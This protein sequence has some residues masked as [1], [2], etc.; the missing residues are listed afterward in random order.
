MRMSSVPLHFVRQ[1]QG[2]LLVLSHALGCDLSM[3]DG[4][5]ERLQDRYTVLRYDHRGHG[6]SPVPMGLWTMDMLAADA[7]ALIE[8]ECEGPVHFAGL[9]MGGMTGQSLAAKAPQRLR[10]LIIINSASHYDEA[11]Q[12]IWQGR[13]RAVREQG[14]SAVAE[15]AMQR[16]FTPAFRADSAGRAQVAALRERL[17]RIPATAYEAACAAVAGIDFRA[18]NS[19]IRCPTLVVAGL[20]DEATPLAASEAMVRQ[21]P[22]A[23]L[24]TI[25]AAHLSA[26]EQPAELAELIDGFI[27]GL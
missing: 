26:V 20:Y 2:P 27:T 15:G 8:A 11:A 19:Q 14:V 1:G 6:R 10:S 13:M 16:W 4:V 3:W 22:G 5:A 9:S 7:L 24:R 12:T 21:I 25:A 17:E 18:S 23:Q